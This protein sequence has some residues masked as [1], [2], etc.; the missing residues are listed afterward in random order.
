MML[1]RKKVGHRDRKVR[2]ILVGHCAALVLLTTLI[3]SA[4]VVPVSAQE[5]SQ[6]IGDVVAV[7]GVEEDIRLCLREVLNT[8]LPANFEPVGLTVA[9]NLDA[10]PAVTMWSRSSLLVV[11]VSPTGL[12][13]HSTLRALPSGVDPLAAAL[14]TRDGEASV[15]ELFDAAGRTI[16]ALNLSTNDVTRFE[17]PADASS[18]SGATRR[19]G[20]WFRA[21]R[22]LDG[23]DVPSRIVLLRP[24]E[25]LPP[26]DLGNSAVAGHEQRGIGRTLHLRSYSNGGF[27]LK[28]AAFPF[29]RVAFARDG[30]E[31]SRSYPEPHELSRLLG[32]SDLRYVIATPAVNLDGAVL[33]TYVALR[34]GRRV[35]ALTLP[36]SKSTRYREIPGDHAFLG[37]LSK[38]RIL[39]GVRSGEPYELLFFEW[40]WIDQR[41]SCDELPT[42][43]GFHGSL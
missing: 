10:N 30:T 5:T 3:G 17:A 33:S 22:I 8:T 39:I 42:Q 21:H 1:N 16:W 2:V 12:R 7:G 35:S 11:S 24:D 27:I 19:I 31:T 20:G 38:H 43:G 37:V 6:I 18:A 32:E 28:E 4:T 34:S 29:A 41:R 26:A 13:I 25:V 36:D 23:T 40:R 14:A 9:E 15:V